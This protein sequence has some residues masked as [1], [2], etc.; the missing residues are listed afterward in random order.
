MSTLSRIGRLRGVTWEWRPEAPEAAH[1]Q[2]GLGVVAQDVQ[3]V[4]PALVQP[5]DGHLTVDYDGL[6]GPLLDCVD[7]LDVR[8]RRVE[9]ERVITAVETARLAA[10]RTSNHLDPAVVGKAIPEAV[11]TSPDGELTVAYH[12]L[13]GVL[14]EAIKELDARLTEVERRSP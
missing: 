1:A 3:A 11:V 6:V 13:V 5:Y 2:P 8:L 14:I 9:G 4:Y 10:G 7:E 12:A